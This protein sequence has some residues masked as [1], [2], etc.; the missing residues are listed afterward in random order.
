MLGRVSL[1]LPASDFTGSLAEAVAV[2]FAAEAGVRGD[3]V[4]RLVRA[5]RCL[6]DFSVERSYDGAGG[7]DVELGLE[8]DE[9]GIAVDVHDWGVPMRRAGGPDGPLPVGLEAAQAVAEDVRLINLAD[10]G[11]RLSLHV[12]VTHSMPIGARVIDGAADDARSVRS[13]A[14]AEMVV[15]DATIEDSTA[16]AQLLYRG[17]SFNYRHRDFYTPRWIEAQWDAGH[18]VS[19]V[20]CAEGQVIGHHALLID[21]PGEAAESGVAVIDRAWRGLGLFDRLFE[22]TVARAEALGVPALYGRATCAHVYSQRSE[23]KHGYRETALL[24]GGSPPA[25]A[26]AQTGDVDEH[27]ER[28]ANL[29]SYLNLGA[30]APRC[31]H[32]PAPYA[33]DLRRLYGHVGLAVAEPDPAAVPCVVPEGAVY[34][35]EDGTARLWLSGDHDQHAV[36]RALRGEGGRLA[37]VV[38][39]DVDLAA[40]AASTVAALRESGFFLSG[41]LVTGRGG[42]DWLRLQRPQG[43]AQTDGLHL[44]GETGQ[45]LLER[46]LADRSTVS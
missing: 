9:R 41:L 14:T 45:W 8:L 36:E 7:G 34:E 38:Y 17:Y 11:K 31:V 4:E 21:A 20:A 30:P 40:P 2:S 42:R 19:T 3:G 27:T 16:I 44:E 37:D 6:V 24:L 46:V 39:A 33:D 23:F 29:I 10:D 18:V 1:T 15:R 43:S 13:A 22:R 28:G 12:P 35:G 32:L 26:Q 5:V 25:M